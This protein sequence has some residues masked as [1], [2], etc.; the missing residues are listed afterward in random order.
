MKKFACLLILLTVWGRVDDYL[1]VAP[2]LPSAPLADDDDEFLLA[3]C[4][5]RADQSSDQEP[6]FAGPKRRTAHSSSLRSGL[7]AERDLTKPFTPPPLYLF[8][9]LQI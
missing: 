4:R 6:V 5:S 1:A 8:M 2:V 3:Q 9:S 7:P